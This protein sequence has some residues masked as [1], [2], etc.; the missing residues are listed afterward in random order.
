MSFLTLEKLK[1][2]KNKEKITMLTAYS[3]PMAK[4]LESCNLDTILV[5]DSLGMVF[6]GKE[7]TLAVTLEEMIYHGQVVRRGAPKT[8]VIVDMPFMSYQVSAEQTL[9]NA[10]KIIKET[11]CNALKLEGCSTVVLDSISKITAAGIPAVGHLGFTPQAVNNLS[12]YKIQ[13]NDQAAA[14]QILADAQKI[15]AAGAF[16]LVLEM[17]PATLAQ[18]IT[19]KLTIPV[20]GIGAGVNC[21]GQVLVI[22]DLLGIY[23]KTP[24]FAKKYTDASALIKKAVSA[25]IQEVQAGKFPQQTHSF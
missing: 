15:E 22:D 21:D 7:N 25:Y 2:K 9:I 10:G 16:M 18:A 14:E 24:R 17:I 8:F 13:G 4:M 11:N 1:N 6:Q 19:Q 20:I 12:G 5:G 23:E 3:Y